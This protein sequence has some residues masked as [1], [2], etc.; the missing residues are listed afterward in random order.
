MQVIPEP[1][2]LMCD[3]VEKCHLQF[4]ALRDGADHP[5]GHRLSDA[6]ADM[7]VMQ[8][9]H[10]QTMLS[11][12]PPAIPMNE[13]NA[14]REDIH[15]P[16]WASSLRT[17]ACPVDLFLGAMP[18]RLQSHPAHRKNY[19][20]P[21]WATRDSQPL[22]RPHTEAPT[23]PADSRPRRRGLPRHTFAPPRQGASRQ[24]RPRALAAS[25]P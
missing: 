20:R 22:R 7:E 6:V 13:E 21:E 11:R 15:H 4:F 2:P 19:V 10:R 9:S 3:R 12:V 1:P 17:W 18:E 14:S 5:D 24:P 8:S 25:D 23:I 16:A